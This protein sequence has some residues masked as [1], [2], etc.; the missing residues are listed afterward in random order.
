[1]RN[2]DADS[3]LW[4]IHGKRQVIYAQAKLTPAR[5]LK[6]ARRLIQEFQDAKR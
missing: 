6:A 2:D 1:V 5:R 3:G 4:K